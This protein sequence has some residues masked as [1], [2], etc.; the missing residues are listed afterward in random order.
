MGENRA[1]GESILGELVGEEACCIEDDH[2]S[3][4]QNVAY[5]HSFMQINLNMFTA[6]PFGYNKCKFGSDPR[7]SFND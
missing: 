2:L 6:E 3:I 5:L 4:S 7:G 1:S